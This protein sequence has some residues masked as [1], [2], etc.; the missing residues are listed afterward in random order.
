MLWN[1][2]TQNVWTNLQRLNEKFVCVFWF[3][4]LFGATKNNCFEICQK[5]FWLCSFWLQ[6]WPTIYLKIFKFPEFFSAET[7][8]KNRH[9]LQPDADVDA[10]LQVTAQRRRD[11]DR[12]QDTADHENWRPDRFRNLKLVFR[13]LTRVWNLEP[14]YL[15]T[16]LA[17]NFVPCHKISYLGLKLHTWVWNYKPGSQTTNQ[18]F[19]AS[20]WK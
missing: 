13:F 7:D 12:G 17:W 4:W 10:I 6:H 11:G 18:T 16:T 14:W 19:F 8:S 3:L 9:L 5:N 20:Q 2:F 15:V 1:I